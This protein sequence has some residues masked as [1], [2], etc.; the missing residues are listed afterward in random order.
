MNSE[1]LVTVEEVEPRTKKEN[2][3]TEFGWN[4]TEVV[5][6]HNIKVPSSKLAKE[7]QQGSNYNPFKIQGVY[8]HFTYFKFID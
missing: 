5:I 1:D 6:W 7:K 2:F 8:M 4:L 3:L